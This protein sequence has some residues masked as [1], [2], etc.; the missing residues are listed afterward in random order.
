MSVAGKDASQKVKVA[1]QKSSGSMYRSR[2]LIWAAISKHHLAED[3]TSV[4]QQI[5]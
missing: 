2:A 5:A 4:E 3:E 1:K